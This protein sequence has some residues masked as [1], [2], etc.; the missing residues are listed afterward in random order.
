MEDDESL[1]TRRSKRSTAGNRMQTALAEIALEDLSK[2]DAEDKDFIETYEE[3]AFESDFTSTDE[4]ETATAGGEQVPDEDK[5]VKK[6][7][8]SRLERAT[9]A[10]HARQKA[11]F[12]PTTASAESEPT[13]PKRKRRVSLGYALNLETGQLVPQNDDASTHNNEDDAD[14]EDEEHKKDSTGQGDDDTTMIT[15]GKRRIIKRSSKRQTTIQN[16]TDTVKRYLISESKILSQPRKKIKR[17]H[18]YTQAELIARALDTE[19]GNL[20]DHRDYLR[21]ER[22]KREMRARRGKVRVEPP[23]LKFVSRVEE[24]EQ[25]QEE[26]ER[27]LVPH[28]PVDTLSSRLPSP[29]LPSTAMIVPSSSNSISSITATP[30]TRPSA[31]YSPPFTF[32]PPSK[33]MFT[34]PTPTAPSPSSILWLAPTPPPPQSASSPYTYISSWTG[35]GKESAWVAPTQV[36]HPPTFPAPSQ[37]SSSSSIYPHSYLF[38]SYEYPHTSAPASNASSL[39]LHPHLQARA[40]AQAS[41]LWATTPEKKIMKKKKVTVSVSKSYLVHELYDHDADDEEE[42]KA[43]EGEGAKA[44]AKEGD[45][46]N[47]KPRL[48]RKRKDRDK[49]KDKLNNLLLKNHKPDWESTMTAVF[50]DHAE[51]GKVQVIVSDTGRRVEGRYTPTCAITGEPAKYLDPR[52]GVPYAD[53]RAYKVLRQLVRGLDGKGVN[54]GRDGTENG[55]LLAGTGSLAGQ[56][57]RRKSEG[58]GKG[59]AMSDDKGE[60]EIHTETETE[61]RK[62]LKEE[63]EELDDDPDYA[64]SVWDEELGCFIGDF[65]ESFEGGEEDWDKIDEGDEKEEDADGLK[66]RVDED[67]KIVLD[68][69]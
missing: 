3:D 45:D 14:A 56:A 58:R 63:D 35:N 55:D 51:W 24:E 43:K 22:E 42:E 1:V 49:D 38:S 37:S 59:R 40:R 32:P 17:H 31:T 50:G 67:G 21:V 53:V 8:K 30:T 54:V 41:E 19:E 26:E 13:K 28:L 48:K 29:P 27:V 34:T 33:P 2:E 10:A 60:G 44:K 23:L 20:I 69:T 16:T 12:N 61:T 4:D 65:L 62:R 5:Q 18:K 39:H 47:Q 11:T 25:E 46:Q 66:E 57:K 7:A 68:L 9:A 52:T 36:H 6:T 15:S 64:I